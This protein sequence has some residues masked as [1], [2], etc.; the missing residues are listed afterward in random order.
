M[1][2]VKDL[3]VTP[4]VG[5]TIEK[6]FDARVLTIVYI[7][8]SLWW[9]WLQVTGNRGDTPSLF[10]NIYAVVSFIAG[11]QGFR[12]MKYWGGVKSIMGKAIVCFTLGLLFQFFGQI[13]YSYYHYVLHV[14]IPYPSLGDIG[15]FGS[16]PWYILGV[17]FLARVSGVTIKPSLFFQKPLA[18]IVPAV[19]VL[20]GYSLFLHGKAVEHQAFL[21]T[22]LDFGYPLLQ[23]IYIS[24]ALV[25]YLLTRSVL[26][27]IM[28][29]VLLFLFMALCF[30]FISDYTFLYQVKIETWYP[31]GIND[32]L[33][34]TSYYL[35]GI[36]LLRLKT[37]HDYLQK[38]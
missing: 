6:N 14:E 9:L 4:S 25:T 32:F 18:I 34:L 35:M 36:G 23:S 29:P 38:I 22:F 24:F 13:A 31:G 7:F 20:I 5:D 21:V 1:N 10:P 17:Y 3:H 19:M 33:Y 28:R 30:Q 26:G 12:V 15:Y 37:V 8:F 16:I 2:N 27:G 11:L